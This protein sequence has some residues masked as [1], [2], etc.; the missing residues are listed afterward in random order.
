MRT[1]IVAGIVMMAMFSGVALAA[2]E[3]MGQ[4]AT[5]QAFRDEDGAKVATAATEY[6]LD[7]PD[8]AGL[9]SA[10]V[11]LG[12]G[13]KLQV[14]LN[15]ADGSNTEIS[16][17]TVDTSLSK[18]VK[19]DGKSVQET[20]PLPDAGL[21]FSRT[22][23]KAKDA[24]GVRLD[25]R[26][27]PE[28]YGEADREALV[29]KW[30]TLPA[31]S[32][33]FFRF[34]AR[35]DARGVAIWIDGRYCGRI[36]RDARLKRL[37]FQLAAGGAVKDV[38]TAA[39]RPESLYL[40]LDVGAIAHPGAMKDAQVS[41]RPGETTINGIPVIMAAAAG[42]ADVGVVKENRG[43]YGLVSDGYLS[44]TALCGVPESLLL[45]VPSAQYVRAWVLCAVEDDS[46][47][48]PILT[49]RLTRFS[50]RNVFE[51]RGQAI[52]DTTIALPRGPEALKPGVSEVGKVAYQS[53]GKSRTVPLY[54]VE[55]PLKAG[56][57]QDLIFQVTDYAMIPQPYLDFELLGKLG[58]PTQQMDN[59]HKPDPQSISG[60][61]IF[62]ATLE[63]SP[64]EMEVLPA[65]AGNV[66]L[67]GEKAEMTVAL[68]PQGKGECRV[69]W[70]IRD[71]GGQS[72]GNGSKT[73]SFAK[74]GDDKTVAVSLAQKGL[75]W[76]GIMFKLL[77]AGGRL[78]VEHPASFVLLDAD[79]RTAGYESP[80]S[81]WWWGGVYGGNTNLNVV[82]P[83]LNRAGIH[84]IS[85]GLRSEAEGAPWKL[86]KSQ[87]VY[88]GVT[89]AT[90][91]EERWT[92]QV[93]SFRQ[94]FPHADTALVLHENYP[95]YYFPF[96]VELYDQPTPAMEQEQID[97]DNRL[98]QAATAASRRYRE[99]FPDVKLVVGNCGDSTKVIAA[100]FRNKFP[101]EYIDY[102]GEEGEGDTIPP[103]NSTAIENWYLA[104]LARKFG[105][106]TPVEACYEWKCRADRDLGASRHAEYSARDALIAHAWRQRLIPLVGLIEPCHSYY[107]TLWGQGYMFSR[108]PEL[109]PRPTYAAMATLTRVLDGATFVRVIPTSSLSVYALEFSHRLPPLDKDEA[110]VQ[111]KKLAGQERIY[112][113]WTA[114]GTAEA[115]LDFAQDASLKATELYGS[116]KTIKTTDRKLA[117][118]LSGAATYL[119]GDAALNAVSVG[120]RAF[121]EDAVPAGVTP[122]VASAMDNAADWSLAAG[123]DPRLDKPVQHKIGV[124]PPYRQSGKY[125]LRKVQDAEKGD[126]LELELVKEG[127]TPALLEEYAVLKAAKPLALPGRPHTVGVWVKG[128][129]SWAKLMWEFEDA[130]GE[131]WFSMSGLEHGCDVYDWP[132]R[133][134][135]NF[136]G[137]NCIQFPIAPESP[138][139]IAGPGELGSQWQST[140]GN[141]KIDYPIKLTGVA[142]SMRRQALNLTEMQEVNNVLRFRDLSAYGPG[143][144]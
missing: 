91:A 141:H 80:Y 26:P 71:I 41:V 25:V 102:M 8:G 124:F 95:N 3:P 107:N 17:K 1:R 46:A 109:Y 79:T 47:K 24:W 43:S 56:E 111:G 65:M 29:G 10:R 110:D 7:V 27:N 113:L 112:V 140:N 97:R 118:T 103:E 50:N 4:A 94:A 44:R 130:E 99:R 123:I 5:G 14:N 100:L 51:G 39:A 82:G 89:T 108:N 139:R 49:A 6:R 83:L 54:L 77:D 78:L 128:N 18:T 137:W 133:A 122:T 21:V 34:D 33:H 73:V 57:I 85:Y 131:S 134:S 42:N 93:E 36:E 55:I 115:T 117:L 88:Y 62:G 135:I 114:R 86:T 23:A 32:T 116:S 28:Y 75:G 59:S 69:Q 48:D 22:G 52:A 120:K 20:T 84:R 98:M 129:S 72:V 142:V 9:A 63:K 66:Y 61:H 126:C 31:A 45:S 125:E 132:G 96:P 40:P 127:K 119:A 121:P 60:V 106:D 64:V 13:G 16:V 30:S 101:K 92:K 38:S 35:P 104:Q 136:D 76:Y 144:L 105:Y 11:K 58:R 53:G 143:S 67:P 138:I 37:T 15:W 74:A 2:G 19:R 90:N 68:R 12:D 87:I 81:A 70:D